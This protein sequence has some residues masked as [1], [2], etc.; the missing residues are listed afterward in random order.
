MKAYK[1][2]K[3][4]PLIY[5]DF[6]IWTNENGLVDSRQSRILSRRRQNLRGHRLIAPTVFLQKGS[7]NHTD[8][9][10]YRFVCQL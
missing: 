2:S 8:L 7:E 3:G 9:D 1:I 5:E 4:D 10:D 6:G